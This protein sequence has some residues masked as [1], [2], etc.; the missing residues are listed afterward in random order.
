MIAPSIWLRTP[1]GL[2]TSPQ[3]IDALTRSTR[4]FSALDAYRDAL[5]GVRANVKADGDAR[6]NSRGCGR[7][8]P[9]EFVRCRFEHAAVTR[10]RQVPKPKLD[11]VHADSRRYLVDV[12]LPGE[13]IHRAPKRPVRARAQR[14][15]PRRDDAA[16]GV[17][18]IR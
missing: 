3:S 10:L 2:K 5:G 7:G 12:R 13:M 15:R 17:R 8:L 9:S 11:R 16:D 18:R 1:S 4:I 6:A 14:R